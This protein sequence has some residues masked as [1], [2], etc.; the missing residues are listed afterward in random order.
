MYANETGG[1]GEGGAEEE[2]E[3][4][5]GGQGEGTPTVSREYSTL[6]LSQSSN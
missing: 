3:G 1:E 6:I 5:E 2:G 4:G